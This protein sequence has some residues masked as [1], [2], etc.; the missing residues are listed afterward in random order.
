MRYYTYNNTCN[1]AMSIRVCYT[2]LS[3][4]PV[5]LS[6]ELVGLLEGSNYA[7]KPKAILKVLPI[8]TPAP[9]KGFELVASNHDWESGG[10]SME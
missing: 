7:V 10:H 1:I 2:V 4:I 6:I 9:P 3:T 5:V 8:D